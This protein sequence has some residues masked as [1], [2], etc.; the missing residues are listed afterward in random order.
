MIPESTVMQFNSVLKK[1][2]GEYKEWGE[3][4]VKLEDIANIGEMSET[5][6]LRSM[7]WELDSVLYE[8]GRRFWDGPA[9][10]R[11]TL[12]AMLEDKP[13]LTGALN[14][15]VGSISEKIKSSADVSWAEIAL[16]IATLQGGRESD[17]RDVLLA[18]RDL[19]V[20]GENA[21]IDMPIKLKRAQTILAETSPKNTTGLGK[22]FNDLANDPTW[23]RRLNSRG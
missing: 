5:K 15:Y 3:Q 17:P 11:T 10:N 23:A 8:M 18:L 2:E 14:G 16:G 6:R 13:H 12:L 22:I 7:S 4:P 20:A 9:S 19:V 21:G 1:F